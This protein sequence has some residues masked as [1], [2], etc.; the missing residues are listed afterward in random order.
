M[1]LLFSSFDSESFKFNSWVCCKKKLYYCLGNFKWI[2]RIIFGGPSRQWGRFKHVGVVRHHDGL[3][4]DLHRRRV[5]T[6]HRVHREG[7]DQV[8][9]IETL[10]WKNS[11][12]IVCWDIYLKSMRDTNISWRYDKNFK[13]SLLILSSPIYLREILLILVLKFC[14]YFIFH[15]CGQ[16]L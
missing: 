6:R 16:K 14:V 12:G 2:F 7:S 3:G 5:V 8:I 4:Q 15:M 9:I 11:H 13:T 10:S 1:V